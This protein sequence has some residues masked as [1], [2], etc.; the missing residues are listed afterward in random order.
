MEYREEFLVAPRAKLLTCRI[1][2]VANSVLAD[3]MCSVNKEPRGAK[4][5]VRGTHRPFNITN[6]EVGC[7][8]WTA[9]P[10]YIALS[11][12]QLRSA[13]EDPLWTRALFFRDPLERFLSAFLSK[14][15]LGDSDGEFMC[16]KVFPHLVEAA[17]GSIGVS[18]ADAAAAVSRPDWE[19]RRGQEMNHFRPQAHFCN[20]TLWYPSQHYNIVV[21]IE[22]SR[23]SSFIKG[24]AV[25]LR[26]AGVDPQTQPAFRRHFLPTQ[27]DADGPA[28]A[29]DHTTDAASSML[30]YYDTLV[31]RNALRAYGED[32][33]ALG[34]PVPAWAVRLAGRDYVS[35]LGLPMVRAAI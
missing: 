2:K 29:Q 19:W 8:W 13:L 15:G 35:L 5:E 32:Y 11:D 34:I 12:Q 27:P 6:F 17:G 10:N 25:M 14:C 24:A 31:T 9:S 26:R 20:G 1:E 30:H 28:P 22:S 21:Q 18:F 33:R 16:R 3:I 4:L 23:P 7:Y